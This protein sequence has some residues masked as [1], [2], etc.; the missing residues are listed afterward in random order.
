[1]IDESLPTV[2]LEVEDTYDNLW[3]KTQEALKY[4]Y[5]YHLDDA[6]W[7]YKSDDDT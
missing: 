3:A 6:D 1:M 5:K 2:V 4:I 7:F